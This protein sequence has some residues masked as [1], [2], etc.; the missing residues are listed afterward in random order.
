VMANDN[1]LPQEYVKN[2]NKHRAAEGATLRVSEG[3]E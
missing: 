3:K 2:M 1:I